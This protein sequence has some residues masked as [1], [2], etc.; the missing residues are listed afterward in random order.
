MNS[1]RSTGHPEHDVWSCSVEAVLQSLSV[2]PERGLDRHE[3]ATRRRIWGR[4][5]LKAAPKRGGLSILI[6]Q[7]KSIVVALLLVAG[8][9]ALLFSEIAEGLAIFAVVLINAAMGFLTEWRAVRSMEALRAF[10]SR[11]VRR[12]AFGG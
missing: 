9:L 11:G 10:R 8:A 3:V 1:A 7:F 4:N 12:A 6:A 5:Q 2:D